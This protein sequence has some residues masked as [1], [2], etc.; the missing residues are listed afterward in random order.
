VSQWSNG[1][2]RTN[3]QLCRATVSY[4]AV[5][6]VRAQML[7]GTGL[8]GVAP[9]CPVQQDNRRLQWSTAQNPNGCTDVA[10]T[11]QCTVIVR[12]RTRLSDAPIASRNHPT[13][14]SGWEAINTPNHLIHCHPGLLKSSF[15]ARAKA[16]HSTIQS[17]QSIHSKPQN[18]L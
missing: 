6:E 14:R 12:W 5:A 7:E 4:S 3:G 16:Q 15:I 10:R 17:K 9:D 18:E 2:L 8:S 11:G 1:S 13:A